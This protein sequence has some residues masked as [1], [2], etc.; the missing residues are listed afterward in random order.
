MCILTS[1]RIFDIAYG[2]EGRYATALGYWLAR[3]SH[4]VTLMGS[5]FS[6]VKS[7]RLSKMEGEATLP[8]SENKRLG[9][10]KNSKKAM[11]LYPPYPIYQASRFVLSAL[12][13]MKIILINRKSPIDLIH[14]QDTGY[15]GLAAVLSG[16]LLDIPVII[17]SHGIRLVTLESTINGIFRKVMLSIERR[18]DNFTAKNANILL[19]ANP[20]VKSYFEQALARRD[21]IDVV[22]LPIKLKKF[23]FSQVN[24][25]ESRRDFGISTDSETKVVGFVGRL[26]PEKNLFT[27]LSSFSN[28]AQTN[29][30][31]KLVLVGAGPLESQL[32]DYVI[33]K[34]IQDRV[35]FYGVSQDVGKVLAGIDVFALPSYTEGLSAALM[36]AMASGRAIVCSDIPG[37]RQLINHNQ[38]GIIVDPNDINELENAI[39]V[40]CDDRELRVKLGKNARLRASQNDEEKVFPQIVQYYGSLI[41]QRRS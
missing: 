28:I 1:A 27:L 3:N 15:S 5:G 26:S 12:W 24:R 14:G 40:L 30:L 33:K 23:E 13:I 19:V 9:N 41:T 38:E 2:G 39:R 7:K 37:N 32:R 8:N 21:R 6:T 18:I 16:K 35:I 4:D 25:E 22:T 11:V 29:S 20:A 31:I 10:E 36:E 34:K 17:T